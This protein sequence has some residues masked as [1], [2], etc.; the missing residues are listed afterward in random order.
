M[1]IYIYIYIYIYTHTHTHT[2]IYI[3]IPGVFREVWPTNL[4]GHQLNQTKSV[5]K[6]KQ[7]TL[8]GVK[9]KQPRI[10][11][12]EADIFLCDFHVDISYQMRIKP[13]ES[14]ANTKIWEPLF[15]AKKIR[16]VSKSNQNLVLQSGDH[17]AHVLP[18]L[19]FGRI[20]KCGYLL[21]IQRYS[22]VYIHIYTREYLYEKYWLINKSAQYHINSRV[23]RIEQN[24]NLLPDNRIDA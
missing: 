12:G 8:Q 15:L 13:S 17:I 24:R 22:L 7:I 21:D 16:E 23:S 10:A 5:R 14:T 11:D 20:F 9:S 19:L 2:H 4:A 18:P 3:Y 6:W 1:C